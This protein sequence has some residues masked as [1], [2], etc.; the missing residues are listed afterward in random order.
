[1]RAS[2]PAG[3][4]GGVTG[5][6]RKQTRGLSMEA[7]LEE[8]E[9]LLALLR[10]QR[11]DAERAAAAAATA[12]AAS[13]ARRSL[14]GASEDGGLSPLRVGAWRGSITGMPSREGSL[15]GR[16][17]SLSAQ[18]SELEELMS[19]LAPAA[20]GGGRSQPR[21]PE[22]GAGPPL[23]PSAAGPAS[24]SMGPASV[25]ELEV[26]FVHVQVA[27][28]AHGSGGSS[29]GGGALV[30]GTDSALL[31]GHH[32]PSSR[33]RTHAFNMDQ[34]QAHMC[35]M[36][37][38]GIGGL[39]WL[40]IA[41]GKL[42]PPGGAGAAG[43]SASRIV[44]PFKLHLLNSK[45]APPSASTPPRASGA[46]AGGPDAGG[47]S[48]V[49]PAAEEEAALH[50]APQELTIQVPSID[51]AMSSRQYELLVDVVEEL[52]EAPLPKARPL[53]RRHRWKEGVDDL[54]EVVAAADM[55][56]AL[57]QLLR[58]M[59]YE[60]LGTCG[61]DG[62][63]LWELEEEEE[64]GGQHHSGGRY[65]GGGRWPAAGNG[66]AAGSSDW[67]GSGGAGASEEAEEEA[68]ERRL[69]AA[70]SNQVLAAQVQ[71]LLMG[72][73]AGRPEG[74]QCYQ[75]VISRN[76]L[77]LCRWALQQLRGSA[78]SAAAAADQCEALRSDMALLVVAERHSM[79]TLVSVDTMRW[80]L[81]KG[82]A[83]FV[84]AT[85]QGITYQTAIDRDHTGSTKIVL[86]DVR[87]ADCQGAVGAVGGGDPPIM[88]AGAVV[89]LWKPDASWCAL[90]TA[91]CSLP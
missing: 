21:T 3:S 80:V 43:S 59:Q 88:P 89:T 5:L 62:R 84:E 82:S 17:G 91:H 6:P 71:A 15:A 87:L 64:H 4:Q 61:G 51:V 14:G 49:S 54:P 45:H 65:G 66:A 33:E 35:D 30:L 39:Q 67:G 74:W 68:E 75:D 37:P 38:D 47:A 36:A 24:S 7:G 48:S 57:R 44:K 42:M 2:A 23:P 32:L 46:Q 29:G 28:V 81:L 69:A 26:E 10:A 63:A 8:E 22:K 70:R 79:S 20:G 1:M 83:P 86:H 60:A 9:Q 72:L 78:L 85:L 90:C 40:V 12:A 11:A 53:I 25:L 73:T 52:V 31:V 13:L 18:G 77:V 55:A 34:V 19:S 41:N 16:E 58:C 50:R 56:R 27:L 76:T